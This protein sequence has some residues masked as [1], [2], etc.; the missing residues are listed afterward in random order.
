[1]DTGE[2]LKLFDRHLAKSGLRL[3]A[4]V[5]G[6][7]ALNLLGVV[8]RFTKD[9]DILYPEIPKDVADASRVFA[10]EVRRTGEILQDDWLNNGPASLAGH[11]RPQWQERLQTVF[12]GAAIHLRCPGRSDF[13]CA[14]LFAL[15]DRGIDLGDC[16]ALAPTAAE[17]SHILPWLA[18][19][20][21][22]PDWPAHVRSTLEDLGRRLGHGV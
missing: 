8:S 4:V 17:L 15:C 2:I 5:I 14:K 12:T 22:N 9:C 13:L 19:Q 6:G 20:D 18:E 10:A 11:L 21:A 3:D 7:A 16:L 1:M